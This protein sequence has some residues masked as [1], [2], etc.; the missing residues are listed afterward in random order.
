ML[1]IV[2]IS[3]ARG[4]VSPEGLTDILA[5]SRRNNAEAGVTGLLVAGGRRFLQALEGPPDAVLA[6]FERIR[7]DERHFAVVD[8]ANR[9]VKARAFGDW[10]MAFEDMG[11]TGA[12]NDLRDAV[13]RLTAD[14]ADP[15]LRAEFQGFAA[16]HAA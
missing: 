15:N 11:D 4:D 14:L 10:A 12:A 1:Q 13:E 3:S 16:L 9:I 8:L 7:R 2:Y 5:A 6:T